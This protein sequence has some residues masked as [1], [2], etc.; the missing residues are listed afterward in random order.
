MVLPKM[1]NFSKQQL[2]DVGLILCENFCKLNNIPLPKRVIIDNTIKHNGTYY[3]GAELIKINLKKNR[4]PTRTPGFA[5]SYPGYKSDMTPIGVLAH[6]FG[7]HIHNKFFNGNSYLPPG[8]VSGYEPNVS[9]AYAES[10]KLFIIN[11]DLLKNISKHRYDYFIESGLKPI[12]KQKW[13][14]VL[15]DAH[16]KFIEITNNIINNTKN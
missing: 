9:E 11:P 16:P 3:Y 12:I 6:E 10:F 4:T 14:D 8:R 2:F 15:S 7:H 5:W 13:D 1:G